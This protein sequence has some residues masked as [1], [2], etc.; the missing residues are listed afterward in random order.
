MSPGSF[1]T[2]G[3]SWA[4]FP[5]SGALPDSLYNLYAELVSRLISEYGHAWARL[6]HS[7]GCPD[8]L[9]RFTQK[10]SPAAFPSL[11]GPGLDFRI[12]GDIISELSLDSISSFLGLIRFPPIVER[13]SRLISKPGRSWARFPHSEH[14]LTTTTNT[15]PCDNK[16][17]NFY[18]GDDNKHTAVG[19]QLVAK[20]LSN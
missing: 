19:C 5:Q 18:V 7:R 11:R 17:R 14:A 9:S 6:P 8:P 10:V 13:V 4:R 20:S 15:K 1:P 2:S 12:P 3:R 16:I